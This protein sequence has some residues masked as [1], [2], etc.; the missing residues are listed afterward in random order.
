MKIKDGSQTILRLSLAA[1]AIFFVFMALVSIRYQIPQKILGH[2]APKQESASVDKKRMYSEITSLFP[3]YKTTKARIVMLGDSLTYS[4]NW[5]EMFDDCTIVNRGISSDTT[6]GVLKRLDNV[7]SLNPEKVFVMIGINDIGL[8]IPEDMTVSNYKKICDALISNGI[9][10]IV[11]STLFTR[12]DRRI[13]RK[14]TSINDAMKE[15]CDRKNIEYIDI[16]S[17]LSFDGALKKEY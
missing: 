17:G 14:V 9:Q 1:N 11:Q 6:E 5:N 12:S 13:N 3:Y 10:P 4:A 8:G 15:F 16:N 2:I 7:I